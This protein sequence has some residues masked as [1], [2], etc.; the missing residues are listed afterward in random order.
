MKRTA[1][2]LLI[3]CSSPAWAKTAYVTDQVEITL[4][5]GASTSH[6]IV[7]ML[8]TGEKLNVLQAD[9]DSG[10]SKVRTAT[11]TEGYVLSRQLVDQPVARDRL[12]A[13]EAEVKS[14]KAAPGELSS[15]LAQLTEQHTALQKSH[16][17][18]QQ[19]KSLVDQEY[20]A[21]QRTANN[22]VRIANERN[23]LRKQVAELTREVEDVKQQNRELENKTAQNWFLIGA[24]VVVGGILLGLILP[25]LRVRRRKSSWGSL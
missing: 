5:T 13:A 4:R 6:R 25:H 17:E 12:A 15:R 20:A 19:A 11:G 8:P 10:Y 14:L 21:L 22:A 9:P 18:L 23:E 24:G 7:R 3:L 2:I 16:E 1:L